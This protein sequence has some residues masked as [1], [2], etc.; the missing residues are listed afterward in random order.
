MELILIFLLIVVNGIFSMSEIAVVSARRA[1]LKQLEKRGD[2]KA[3]TAL[4]LATSP[5]IFLATIQIGIT[6]VGVMTGAFGEAL[7]ADDLATVFARIDWLAPYAEGVALFFVIV[8]ITFFSLVIGELVPKRLGLNNPE[9]IARTMALPMLW[10][11]RATSPLVRLL[12]ASTELILRLLRVK[13]RAEVPI[14]E[15]ELRTLIE[16]GTTAGVFAHAERD[17]LKNV[18]R[19]ADRPIDTLMQPRAEIVWLDLEEPLSEAHRKMAHSPHSRFPVARGGLD[20]LVGIV[21]AKDLLAQTLAGETIDIERAMQSALHVPDTTTA[22][23]LLEIFKRAPIPTAVIVD[24]Y[25]EIKGLVTLNDLLEAIVGD[26]A[27][28]DTEGEQ[29]VV[30]RPDGSWLL[31]GLLPIGELKELLNIGELPNEDAAD[32]QTLGG[33]VMHQ[34]GRIPAIAD[35][36]D[37]QKYRFEVVDMDGKRID[38]VL[39]SPL[40]T[41]AAVLKSTT[42]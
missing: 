35:T 13:P 10:L 1:R 22:L 19:L 21:Q 36:F 11:S 26:I 24:E 32:Y 31:D 34:L 18:L 23:R 29:R 5:N 38:R 41:P 7:V 9:R 37:W 20:N 16:E 4:Q 12:G 17:L 6:L 15:D 3:R 2:R 25:G 28:A 8:G 42:P 30:R 14:T 39:V 40:E 33:M 27:G